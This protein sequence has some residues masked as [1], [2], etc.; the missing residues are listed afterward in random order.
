MK[1]AAAGWWTAAALFYKKY[2]P[3]KYGKCVGYYLAA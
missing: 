2:S 1:S 3:E